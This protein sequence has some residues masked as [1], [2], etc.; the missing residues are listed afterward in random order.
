MN[1]SW[2]GFLRPIGLQAPGC[3]QATPRLA[4]FFQLVLKGLSLGESF[5][6]NYQEL[7]LRARMLH[8]VLHS[9]G[10]GVSIMQNK[11]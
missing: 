3:G 9:R 1:H 6:C 11:L 7:I 10:G 5:Y 4:H 8:Q 2:H